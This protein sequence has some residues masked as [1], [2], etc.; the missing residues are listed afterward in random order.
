MGRDNGCIRDEL[1]SARRRSQIGEHRQRKT[2]EVWLKS[3]HAN[4]SEAE[5]QNCRKD[6]QRR[7][8]KPTGLKPE[9]AIPG[10][11]CP[12]GASQR[13]LHLGAG[14]PACP[15]ADLSGQMSERQASGAVKPSDS[16][17]ERCGHHQRNPPQRV[18]H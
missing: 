17:A 10:G 2:H 5:G 8:R 3:E 15:P 13:G 11:S 14:D 16:E 7:E 6:W 1:A 18:V 4:L 12:V 9:Q